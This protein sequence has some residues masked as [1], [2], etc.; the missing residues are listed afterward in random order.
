ML[1]A[2]LAAFLFLHGALHASYL[3]PRPPATPGGPAWPFLLEGSW[4]LTPLG[5]TPKLTRWLGIVLVVVTVAAFT[6][7][8]AATLGFVPTGL[9]TIAVAVGAGSSI[10][11]LAIYFHPWLVVG[12]AID[13]ALILAA[14]VTRW[15]PDALG[16]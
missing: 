3:T 11:L 7:G 4:I 16:T 15:S 10:A 5:V 1:V 2:L 12:L 6:L 9:W 8:A 14:F 13:I